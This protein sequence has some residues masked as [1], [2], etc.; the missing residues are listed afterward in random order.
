MCKIGERFSQRVF[1]RGWGVLVY[2]LRERRYHPMAPIFRERMAA[3]MD[4]GVVIYING[5]RL[6][7]LRALPHWLVAN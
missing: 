5:M 3:E 1:S 4:D 2:H 6:N 7:K